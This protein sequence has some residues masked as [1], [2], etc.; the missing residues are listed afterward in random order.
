MRQ[1]VSEPDVVATTATAPRAAPSRGR[2]RTATALVVLGSITLTIAL[3][4]GWAQRTVFDDDEFADRAVAV[5]QSESV[6]HALAVQITDQVIQHGPS[7]LASYRSPLIG[8]ADDVIDTPAFQDIFR[9]AVIDAHRTV[10]ER[11][12]ARAL[13]ELG[14]SLKLLSQGAR[15]SNSQVADQL[16]DAAGSL[17][18]DLSPS[19]R[20]IDLWQYGQDNKWIDDAAMVVTALAF[21][22]AVL[23]ERRRRVLHAIGVGVVVAGIAVVLVTAAVPPIVAGVVDNPSISDAIH[24]GTVDFIA[25]LRALG[26]WTIPFGLILAAA[27]RAS[28]QSDATVNLRNFAHDIRRAFAPDAPRALQIA[29][30]AGALVVGVLLIVARSLM[31]TLVVL[32][33]GTYVVYRAAALLMLALLGPPTPAD[34]PAAHVHAASAHPRRWL[35]TGTAALA[36]VVLGWVLVTNVADAGADARAVSVLKCNGSEDLCDRPLNQVAFATSHNSMSAESDDGWFFAENTHGIASQL[37]YGVRGLLV[38]THYG[39]QTGVEIEGSPLVVTDRAS[40]IEYDRN[41]EIAELGKEAVETVERLQVNVPPEAVHD[42]YMCHTYC[43]LG[44]TKFSGALDQIDQFITRNPHEVVL[45][46]IGDYVTEAD[47]QK[48]FED[49]GLMRHLWQYDSSKPLP[50]LREMIRAKRTV[51]VMA[52]RD[53]GTE[54][55]YSQAYGPQGLVQDTPFKFETTKQFNC[56][57][58]RGTKASPIFQINHWITTTSPPSARDAKKVNSYDTLMGRVRACQKERGRFPTIVGV[59]FY[60][61]GDLLRVVHDLNES[62]APT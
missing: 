12:G 14:E 4:A 6:R 37:A 29:T 58:Y 24:D 45:M 36:F 61:Q 34:A 26:L 10:F 49:A 46:I 43:E 9:T 51:F 47:T 32:A 31:V 25:D 20:A 50:T 1:D 55:W 21:G 38:K 19:L 23:L 18:V 30:G 7:E 33:V 42:V 57:P 27:A 60:D 48:A 40:E 5:L 16:P 59:N 13:L 17:L 52:E 11:H 35:V 3:I 53:A 39:F 2:T 56:N 44:A 15:R 62:P 41:A 54:P 22:G 28:Q 8:L